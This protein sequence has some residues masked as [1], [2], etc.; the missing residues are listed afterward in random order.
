M[1]DEL[2]RLP[3]T[4]YAVLGMLT[5]ADGIT[6]YELKQRADTSLAFFYWSPAMSAVYTELDR[7]TRLGL[8]TV[9]AVPET[10]LRAKKIYHITPE[11]RAAMQQWIDESPW[12]PPQLKNFTCLRAFY[13]HNGDPESVAE[14]AERHVAWAKGQV[15]KLKGVGE[16]TTARA[17]TDRKRRFALAVV[18]WG[19]EY[20]EREAEAAQRLALRMRELRAADESDG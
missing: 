10:E 16:R 6:A 11:G 2:A 12:E 20:F 5:Y 19:L 8:V 17:A 3:A 15:E 13:G 9:D 4:A 14:S 1:A 7:L 18:E